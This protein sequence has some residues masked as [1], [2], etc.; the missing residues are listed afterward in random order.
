MVLSPAAAE[1]VFQSRVAARAHETCIAPI[2]F[3]DAESADSARCRPD[4]ERAGALDPNKQPFVFGGDCSEDRLM[5]ECQLS[6]SAG[7]IS[8]RWPQDDESPTAASDS[9]CSPLY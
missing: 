3:G 7:C 1:P 6:A 2:G 5:V 9:H 4:S 8:W